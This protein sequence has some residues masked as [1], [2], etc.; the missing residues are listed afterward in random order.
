MRTVG[1]GRLPNEMICSRRHV[2]KSTPVNDKR[3]KNGSLSSSVVRKNELFTYAFAHHRHA[4]KHRHL[5][6]L[7]QISNLLACDNF[8]DRWGNSTLPGEDSPKRCIDKTPFMQ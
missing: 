3:V 8:I 1:G 5:R 6:K 7:I 2:I 4:P